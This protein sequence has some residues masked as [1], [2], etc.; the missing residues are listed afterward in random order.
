MDRWQDRER[1]SIPDIPLKVLSKRFRNFRADASRYLPVSTGGF[2]ATWV[3]HC[4]AV[5]LCTMF[6]WML[7]TRG[8]RPVVALAKVEMMIDVS[9]EMCRP[10]V[11]RPRPNEYTA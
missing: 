7:A 5:K 9:V 8:H 6:R 10:V 2:M 4:L 11:P 1:P 3:M